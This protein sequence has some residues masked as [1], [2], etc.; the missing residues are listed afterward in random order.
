MRDRMVVLLCKM[1]VMMTWMKITQSRT[2]IVKCVK[3]GRTIVLLH[4]MGVVQ[5]GSNSSIIEICCML[6]ILVSVIS[7]YGGKN[8]ILCLFVYAGDVLCGYIF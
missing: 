1:P 8:A 2:Y 7:N 5:A 3:E 4:A 6:I